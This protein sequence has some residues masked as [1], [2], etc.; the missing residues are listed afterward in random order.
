MIAY[1]GQRKRKN[2]NAG[3]SA[4]D[5]DRHVAGQLK[6]ARMEAGLTQKEAG[7]LL[8]VSHQQMQKYE[9]GENRLSLGRL[10]VLAEAYGKSI[11][12]FVDSES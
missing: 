11:A 9:G 1:P 5:L 7:K 2:P 4:Y 3:K 8:G 12:W 6:R 10:A